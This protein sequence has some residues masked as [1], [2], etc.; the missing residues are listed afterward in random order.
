MIHKGLVAAAC[1]T[2][3][4]LQ[5]SSIN[6]MLGCTVRKLLGCNTQA[7]PS[8][9]TTTVCV[10]ERTDC[11]VI[12]YTLVM[13]I[14][15]HRYLML[16]TQVWASNY[17]ALSKYPAI[18]TLAAAMLNLLL[19]DAAVVNWYAHHAGMHCEQVVGIKLTSCACSPLLRILTVNKI[20]VGM[21]RKLLDWS[22]DWITTWLMAK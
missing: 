10:E 16:T 2:Y 3:V 18:A 19:R 5:C 8:T 9:T 13:Q 20:I 7:L 22:A 1:S 11:M 4:H 12:I 21:H 15:Q 17:I 14:C 6:S